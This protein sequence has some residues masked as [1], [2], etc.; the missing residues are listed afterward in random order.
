[1]APQNI[2]STKTGSTSR[3]R[4]AGNTRALLL[5]AARR[6]FADDG[7]VETRVRDI[8]R[9]AGVNVALINRYFSSKEGLFE[10]CL[11]TTVD[12][13]DE[14]I[15]R[16]LTLEQ[17]L[18]IMSAQISS[19]NG[20]DQLRLMLL[21]RSSGDDRA[22]QIRR[23]VFR[24]FSERIAAAF[25]WHPDQ[26]ET[27]QT[28]LRA[29]MTLSAILGIVIMRSTGLEPLTSVDEEALAAPLR[30]LLTALLTST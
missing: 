13:F 16:T 29:E 4:D 23:D 22:D 12:Q 25:G 19:P 24:S 15:S 8:A 6:R 17:I 9:D 11:A 28:L 3:P 30:D 26:P 21:L 1:M 2:L 10:A 18:P 5:A 27:A 20:D 14:A 7:Y